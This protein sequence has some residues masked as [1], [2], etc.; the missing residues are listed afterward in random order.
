MAAVSMWPTSH[1]DKIMAGRHRAMNNL[2]ISVRKI[3]INYTNQYQNSI[4]NL[5]DET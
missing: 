5:I 2:I 4:I 3:I 1:Q